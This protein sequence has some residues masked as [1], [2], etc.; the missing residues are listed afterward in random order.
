MLALDPSDPRVQALLHA[1]IPTVFIDTRGQGSHATYVD[2]NHVDAGR[3]VAEHL[4]ALGHRRIAF[5][6]GPLT[7]MASTERLLGCQQA[8]TQAGVMLDP[9]L[10]CLAGWSTE[11]AHQAA[12]AFLNRRR[13]FTAII[14]GSD[15]MAI[16]ILRALHECGLRVPHDVSLTGF[17]D[18]VLSQYTTPSLTTVR[19]DREAMGRGAVQRLAA[20]IDGDAD[21]SPLI[22]P[23]QLIVRESTGP[24]TT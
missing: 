1:A 20:L 16:G 5:L 14:A 11:E 7:D 12:R 21:R 15:M 13:D 17:D 22:I 10:L 6:I 2:S 19:T 8:L 9:G 23:T 4:L 18:V 24:A 3:Q